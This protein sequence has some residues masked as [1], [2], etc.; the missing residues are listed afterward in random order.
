MLITTAVL[1]NGL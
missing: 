1:A